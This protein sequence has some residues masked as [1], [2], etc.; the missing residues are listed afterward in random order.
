[1]RARTLMCL[2][3]PPAV[4]RII[5]KPL[6]NVTEWQEDGLLL[7]T[8]GLIDWCHCTIDKRIKTALLIFK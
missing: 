8:Y 5:L 1:M 4:R 6:C 2:C 7:A 3:I